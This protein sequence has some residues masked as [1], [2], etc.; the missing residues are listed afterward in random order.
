MVIEGRYVSGLLVPVAVVVVGHDV[1]VVQVL[2]QHG[3]VVAFVDDLLGRGDGGREEEALGLEGRAQL[4]HQGRE[5]VLVGFGSLL[6]VH[7]REKT[8]FTLNL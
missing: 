6:A 8:G 2:V 5:A 4:L 7:L 1:D 3:Y